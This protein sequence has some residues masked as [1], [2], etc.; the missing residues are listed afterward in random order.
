M[1]SQPEAG[2]DQSFVPVRQTGAIEPFS[3]EKCPNR[4]HND[5]HACQSDEH[6]A[7]SDTPG[8]RK[9]REDQKDD[10]PNHEPFG[11]GC[12]AWVQGKANKA[13]KPIAKLFHHMEHPKGILARSSAAGDQCLGMTARKNDANGGFIC[14]VTQFLPGCGIP[15]QPRRAGQS[16]QMLVTCHLGAEQKIDKIDASPVHRFKRDGRR[17]ARENRHRL[18]DFRESCVGKGDALTDTCAAHAL[19]LL[20]GCKKLR[21]VQ[22]RKRGGDPC[23]FL[24]QCLLVAR[25][26]PR[27]NQINH[28]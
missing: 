13:T 11:Y 26:Q 3:T 21:T 27:E 5:I 8:N 18:S 14:R 12:D 4:A 2:H 17:Q 6:P 10:K 15:Q 16:F 20:Q 23:Q 19:A 9:G 24:Q 7:K 1:G 25:T 28:A 22:L